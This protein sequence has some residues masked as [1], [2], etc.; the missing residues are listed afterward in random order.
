M[1]H[2]KYTKNRNGEIQWN[3]LIKVTFYLLYI[4]LFNKYNICLHIMFICVCLCTGMCVHVSPWVWMT[5]LGVS[6]SWSPHF[7][8]RHGVSTEPGAHWFNQTE[9]PAN[10]EFPVSVSPVLGF[11]GADQHN[12]CM[13]TGD[14]NSST[15]S[16]TSMLLTYWAIFPACTWQFRD[17]FWFWTQV[18]SP[19][20]HWHP[21]VVSRGR[22]GTWLLSTEKS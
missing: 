1:S 12:P 3:L 19:L 6:F 9:W 2:F 21:S 5:E 20:A 16:C 15:Q 4:Y 22:G 18:I 10:W 7:F 11:I 17:G 14:L 8:L 13:S